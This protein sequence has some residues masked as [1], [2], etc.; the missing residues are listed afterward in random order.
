MVMSIALHL[1][2]LSL[3]SRHRMS[4][5]L[6]TRSMLRLAWLLP[7]PSAPPRLSRTSPFVRWSCSKASMQHNTA[8]ST[9]SFTPRTDDHISTSSNFSSSTITSPSA[10]SP[11]HSPPSE[12]TF[13][14][15]VAPIR[16]TAPPPSILHD[17]FHRHHTYLRISLT[18]R[19]NLR[20]AYC[21]P[22]DGVPLTPTPQLL[23]S[24]EVHRVLS[25]FVA[26]G[27]TKVRFTGGEPTI[28]PDLTSILSRAA[29]LA[30]LGLSTI[31][32]TT[33]GIVLARRL[34]DYVRAG[35]THVNLSLDTLDA[36]KFALLTRRNGHDKVMESLH[37]CL[38]ALPGGSTPVSGLT[39]TEGPGS[40]LKSVKLNCV[41]MKKL[42]EDEMV[43]AAHMI[44][45]WRW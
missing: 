16:R 35:L 3:C 23:T 39:A 29:T 11:P 19:C 10:P 30:P 28:R 34:H 20:C 25:L 44:T 27:V 33:N 45:G 32:M 6:S 38:N 7:L 24:D 5:H 4:F 15:S 43:R 37:A 21:M 9:C 36:H 13:I 41:V 40:G 17:T 26:A 2:S 12:A 22:E 1:S 8:S 42:N 18:E 14:P 31:G